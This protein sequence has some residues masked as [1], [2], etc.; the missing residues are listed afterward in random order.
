MISTR[1]CLLYVK[2]NL[3]T[4]GTVNITFLFYK[5]VMFTLVNPYIPAVGARM[6]RNE[7]SGFWKAYIPEATLQTEKMTCLVRVCFM[8]GNLIR[9]SCFLFYYKARI[10]SN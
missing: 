4:W 10:C 5:N 1:H 7:L 9:H 6:K 8:K 3:A 2:F